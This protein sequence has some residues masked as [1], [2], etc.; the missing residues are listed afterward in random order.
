M[1]PV[2]LGGRGDRAARYPDGPV[3]SLC[4]LCL[5]EKGPGCDGAS[6]VGQR[7]GSG[8]GPWLGPGPRLGPG[9]A[10]WLG[11]PTGGCWPWARGPGGGSRACVLG[12]V[13][14]VSRA[15]PEAFQR[16]QVLGPA[17]GVDLAR[18]RP[19][20]HHVPICEDRNLPCPAGPG[21]QHMQAAPRV[22]SEQ[23]SRQH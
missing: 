1:V 14:L 6:A 9:L 17:L 2:H 23:R 21:P 3:S 11:A 22:L 15:S 12:E 19:S 10:L 16:Q 7:P 4:A 5:Q 8:A 18:P 13:T 20:P